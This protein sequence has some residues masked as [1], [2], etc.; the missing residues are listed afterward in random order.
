MIQKLIATTTLGSWVGIGEHFEEVTPAKP[1]KYH[2]YEIRRNVHSAK[3][4]LFVHKSENKNLDRVLPTLDAKDI[5]PVDIGSYG[6][7][8]VKDEHDKWFA[9]KNRLDEWWDFQ[10][11]SKSRETTDGYVT[12]TNCGDGCFTTYYNE[13]HSA[14][15][16]DDAGLYLEYLLSDCESYD[17]RKVEY[18]GF[19]NQ[20]TVS[21]GGVEKKVDI[22]TDKRKIDALADIIKELADKSALTNSGGEANGLHK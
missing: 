2:I 5:C 18:F 8:T 15:L 20:I 19:Q 17:R 4:L 22:P 6:I 21:Y 1:G 14:F 9:S 16:L 12:N 10:E 3:A 7:I 11:R 13:T